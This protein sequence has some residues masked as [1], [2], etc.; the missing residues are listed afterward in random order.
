M[1]LTTTSRNP[2][3]RAREP[4]EVSHPS[5]TT[6]ALRAGNAPMVIVLDEHCTREYRSGMRR[7]PTTPES[8][9]NRPMQ[10]AT[11]ATT[12]FTTRCSWAS[13]EASLQI[14]GPHDGGQV[15]ERAQPDC[16]VEIDGALR[17]GGEKEHCQCRLRCHRV[18]CDQTIRNSRPDNQPDDQ[19]H[20]QGDLGQADYPVEFSHGSTMTLTR[21]S[22]GPFMASKFSAGSPESIHTPWYCSSERCRSRSVIW[23]ST[24]TDVINPTAV[25]PAS[26]SWSVGTITMPLRS[27]RDGDQMRLASERLA[28]TTRPTA[29]TS[30]LSDMKRRTGWRSAQGLAIS[31]SD[32][33]ANATR[34]ERP[35]PKRS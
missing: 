20:H 33:Q 9:K 15:T 35:T 13:E 32:T 23:L 25:N 18:E 4:K 27:G 10:A 5:P 14:T 17:E 2:T 11:T 34:M 21:R 3:M 26:E 16:D 7:I 24:M 8:E 30:S 12:S 28:R 22:T 19:E 29:L 31:P 6:V 1:G